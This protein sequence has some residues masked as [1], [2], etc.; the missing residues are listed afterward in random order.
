MPDVISAQFIGQSAH[1]G[2]NLFASLACLAAGWLFLDAWVDR[3]HA[4]EL[5]KGSGFILL[6]IAFLLNGASWGDPSLTSFIADLFKIA[7]YLAIVVG[8]LA[9]SLNAR[10]KTMGYRPDAAFT[11]AAAL[12]ATTNSLVP[13][14]ALAA[15][16]VYLRLS[17]RG[18]E[19]HLKP[20]ALAFFTFTLSDTLALT[21]RWTNSSNPLL[22]PLAAP[23]GPLWILQHLTLIAAASLLA[24]WVWRYLTKRLLSQLFL[25]ITTLTFVVVLVATTSVAALLLGS[26]QRDSL[27]SLETASRVLSYAVD[28]KTADTRTNAEVLAEN[29]AISTAV[30]TRDQ[31]SLN[32]LSTNLLVSKKLSEV[33]ITD[34][35]GRVLI[36]ASDPD[37]AGDSISNDPLVGRA[38]SGTTAAGI[39][40]RTTALTPMLVITTATPVAYQGQVVGAV[41]TSLAMD[42]AFVDGLKRKTG[43]DSTVYAGATRAATTLTG[44][45]GISR[46]LGTKE[47]SPQVSTTV[48]GGQIWKGITNVSNEPYLSVYLPLKNINGS[49]IGMLFV[50]QPQDAVISSAKNALKLTFIGASVALLVITLPIFVLSSQISR[51][52]H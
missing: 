25:I 40:T 12:S 49:T 51:Q 4:S 48:K 7:G 44:P 1:F 9:V 5:S 28:S 21:S 31:A 19:R 6:A 39:T 50:G 26:L 13:L 24:R 20:L 15:C 2:V 23:L 18:L 10:P 16:L 38:L 37:R 52:L 45:D 35:T 22:Q 30:S 34:E 17:T 33:L 46:S 14:A 41:L 8:N 27:A 42:N 3:P 11:P 29:P 36:R 47:T 43:L 32:T